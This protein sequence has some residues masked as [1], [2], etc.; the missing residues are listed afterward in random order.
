MIGDGK[1]A[2]G[3]PGGRNADDLSAKISAKWFPPDYYRLEEGGMAAEIRRAATGRNEP[4]DPQ[5]LD[6]SEVSS[7]PQRMLYEIVD[8]FARRRRTGGR[9][10]R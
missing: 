7:R 1:V 8:L 5:V 3:D 4:Q 9:P 6:D 10:P 2:R